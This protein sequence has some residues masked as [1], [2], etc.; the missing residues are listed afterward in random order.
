MLLKVWQNGSCAGREGIVAGNLKT[1]FAKAEEVQGTFRLL[2]F[3]GAFPQ[4]L[5]RIAFLDCAGDGIEFIP[6]APEDEY[7]VVPDVTP[8][9]ALEQAGDFVSI[10]PD[11]QHISLAKVLDT[12]GTILGFEVCP[13]YSMTAFGTSDVLDVS[14]RKKDGSVAIF[15]HLQSGVERQLRGN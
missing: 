2:L 6:Y 4:Q 7:R 1:M 11:F 15:V 14:Y 12:D 5:G 3:W 13:H 9:E 10:H 8:Q